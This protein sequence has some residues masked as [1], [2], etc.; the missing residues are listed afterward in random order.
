[1]FH[2]KKYRFIIWRPQVELWY[3]DIRELKLFKK[4]AAQY[5]FGPTVSGLLALR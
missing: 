4:Y 5:N 3:V 1:M 2:T